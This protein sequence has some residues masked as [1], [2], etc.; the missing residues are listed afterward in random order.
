MDETGGCPRLLAIRGA[1]GDVPHRDRTA[2]PHP[3]RRGAFRL[4]THLFGI[5]MLAGVRMQGHFTGAA[6]SRAFFGQLSWSIYRFVVVWVLYVAI[7]PYLRRLWPRTMISWAR[8][9]EGRW[10]DPLVGRD[11]LLGAVAAGVM[12]LCLSALPLISGWAG[13]PALASPI[14]LDANGVLPLAGPLVGLSLMLLLHSGVLATAGLSL[15]VLLVL[16]RLLTRRTWIAVA[17][18]LPLIVALNIGGDAKRL[19]FLFFGL[20]WLTIFFRLGVLA[21]MVTLGLTG[22]QIAVPATLSTS[23]WYAGPSWIFFALLT[24]VSVYGF[25]VALGGSGG[26]WHK[27]WTRY[28]APFPKMLE[29]APPRQAQRALLAVHLTSPPARDPVRTGLR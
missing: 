17:V 16:L 22:L 2:D 5:R 29:T 10:R 1:V 9:L 23:V 15:V 11:C 7:E 25:V 14:G 27:R 6:S 21:L 26:Q 28:R 18:W 20:L 8:A 4:G 19:I 13:V 3:D 24:A 12:W